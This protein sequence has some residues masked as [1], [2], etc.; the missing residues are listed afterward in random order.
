MGSSPSLALSHVLGSAW[1]HVPAAYRERFAA[2]LA[3]LPDD[4]I[5]RSWKASGGAPWWEPPHAAGE[6]T[7]FVL[8]DAGAWHDAGVMR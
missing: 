6:Q 7:H 4:G 5:S 8:D 3:E 1:P 2:R